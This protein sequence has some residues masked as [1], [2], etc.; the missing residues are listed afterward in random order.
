MTGYLDFRPGGRRRRGRRRPVLGSLALV[1]L[2]LSGCGSAAAPASG[3][4]RVGDDVGPP[5]GL[6][7]LLGPGRGGGLLPLGRP[8]AGAA[9]GPVG[10]Q[11]T[12]VRAQR[13]DR[14]LD[15]GLG[16]D[17]SEPAQ[18]RGT[19]H[20]SVQAAPDGEEVNDVHGGFTGKDLYVP[21][22]LPH[23]TGRP[24]EDAPADSTGVFNGQSTYTGCA[25]DAEHNMFASDIGTA[26]GSFPIPDRR[27]PGRVVRPL[28]HH[29]RASSTGPTPEGWAATPHRRHRRAVPAGHDDL[30]CQ[31]RHPGAPRRV[32]PGGFPGNVLE[33]DHSSFPSQRLAVSRRPLPPSPHQVVGVLPGDRP[34]TC[35]CPWRGPRPDL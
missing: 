9:H 19:P 25:V 12:D 13:R 28:L 11:R 18:S 17:Q 21:G 20:L 27:T 4:D 16:P 31:R 33:F 34:T 5:V 32:G 26:Q 24:G 23:G 14:P 30:R 10:P 7:R 2:V 15:R 6:S 1:A 29:V 8:I 3:G 35:R 22:A